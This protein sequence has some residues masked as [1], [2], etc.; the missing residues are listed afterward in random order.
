MWL[1]RDGR[2]VDVSGAEFGFLLYWQC[3]GEVD[4]PGRDV[5]SEACGFAPVYARG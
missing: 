1:E 2:R 4:P 5:G 3:G